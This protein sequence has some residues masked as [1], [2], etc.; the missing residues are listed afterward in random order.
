MMK[1]LLPIVVVVAVVGVLGYVL[2]N[3][4]TSDT[5]D[6]TTEVASQDSSAPDAFSGTLKDA[7]KLGIAMK[8]TY[9]VEGNEYESF[10]K[11][12]NY[13]GKIKT[14]EGKT[15]EVIMKNNC[16]W[17]WTEGEVQGIKTCFEV[18]DSE[19]ADVWEQPQGAVGPDITYTCL[20]T[21]ITD[22][23]FTP[24]SNVDFMDLDAMKEGFGY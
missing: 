10:I 23:S 20:P 22:A 14:A 15:G 17:T 9:K 8:C 12:E 4:G 1:K 13:R 18:S 19:T 7:V 24:P 6:T 11:G 21:A 5:S 3:Q 16:M 2:L